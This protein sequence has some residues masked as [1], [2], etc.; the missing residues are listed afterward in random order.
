MSFLPYLVYWG[1]SPFL[2]QTTIAQ[3]QID[4]AYSFHEKGPNTDSFQD[5]IAELGN[6]VKIKIAQL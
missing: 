1:G 3:I 5:A 2:F 4:P 6:N